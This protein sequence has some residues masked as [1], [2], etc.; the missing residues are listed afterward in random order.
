MLEL[1]FLGLNPITVPGCT[2]RVAAVDAHY[3]FTL[4]S[5]TEQGCQNLINFANIHNR[6]LDSDSRSLL[7]IMEVKNGSTPTYFSAR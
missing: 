4:C 1:K 3:A 5:D 2:L 6:Y 7:S